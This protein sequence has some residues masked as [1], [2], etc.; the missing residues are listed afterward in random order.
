MQCAK[1]SR[2]ENL[3]MNLLHDAMFNH[4]SSNNNKSDNNKKRNSTDCNVFLAYIVSTWNLEKEHI[5][6]FPYGRGCC[7]CSRSSCCV[8]WLN[9][10]D[11]KAMMKKTIEYRLFSC[12]FIRFLLWQDRPFISAILHPLTYLTWK[13]S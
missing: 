2:I 1:R 6:N 8:H 3:H 10:D 12:L 7:C 9:V 4:I 11:G 5:E 13:W